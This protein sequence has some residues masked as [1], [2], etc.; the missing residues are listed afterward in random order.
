MYG[1]SR[2]FLSGRPSSS[3]LRLRLILGWL[4]ASFALSTA[5]AAAQDTYGTAAEPV[6]GYV[7]GRVVSIT[8]GDTLTI[9]TPETRRSRFAWP[10]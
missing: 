2:A 7:Y 9:L 5:T 8:D 3:R 1:G 6:P 10:K 4:L